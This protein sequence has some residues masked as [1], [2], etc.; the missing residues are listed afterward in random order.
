MLWSFS[1]WQH[2]ESFPGTSCELTLQS[3]KEIR[4]NIWRRPWAAGEKQAVGQLHDRKASLVTTKH[5]SALEGSGGLSKKE[6]FLTL[7]FLRGKYTASHGG[8]HFS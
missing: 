1:P 8:A 6:A 2:I 3:R 7:R 5:C 4:E